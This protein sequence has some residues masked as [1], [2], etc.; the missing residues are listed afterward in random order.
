MSEEA[1]LERAQ[2]LYGTTDPQE[3]ARKDAELL[4]KYQEVLAKQRQ[5][6]TT[7]RMPLLGLR[8]THRL[9]LSHKA[10][11]AAASSHRWVGLM[12]RGLTP[13]PTPPCSTT[14]SPSAYAPVPG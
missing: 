3:I 2:K 5:Q 12:R 8:L 10:A 11:I 7:P 4:K 1:R 13:A 6:Q 14:P 9:C